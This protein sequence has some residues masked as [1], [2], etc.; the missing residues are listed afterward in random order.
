MRDL[1]PTRSGVAWG[2]TVKAVLWGFLGVRQKKGY[3]QDV[4]KLSP[5]HLLAV[6]LVMAIVF[7]G[8]LMLFVHWVVGS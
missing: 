1:L 7:V 8:M 5:L 2:D 6:G 3:H 4:A